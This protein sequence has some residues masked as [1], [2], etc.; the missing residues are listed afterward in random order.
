M[1]SFLA[2]GGEEDLV[3]FKLW[4]KLAMAGA[5][6][7][8]VLAGVG[9]LGTDIWLASTQWLLAASVLACFGIYLRLES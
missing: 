7:G 1:L 6:V 9:A 4:S 8:A 3:D 2:K 5:A